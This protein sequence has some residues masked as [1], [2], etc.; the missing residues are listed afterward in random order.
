MLQLFRCFTYLLT[1]VSLYSCMLY[2]TVQ[3][4]QMQ[5]STYISLFQFR[6]NC[7][8]TEL[9]N[10]NISA[11]SVQLQG[12]HYIVFFW[13]FLKIFRTYAFL[14]FP[15]V[16]TVHTPGRQ[17]ISAATELGEFRKITKFYRKTQY[18]MNT[19][20][21]HFHIYMHLLTSFKMKL[22][23]FVSQSFQACRR[24]F[25]QQLQGVH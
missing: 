25:R 1:E 15:L 8:R 24:R 23:F 6:N 16:C 11:T 13:R 19:L 22:L 12:V 18:I 17:N 7:S 2:K 20:Q 3:D 14:C 10:S 4:Q 21:L 9:A 5:F